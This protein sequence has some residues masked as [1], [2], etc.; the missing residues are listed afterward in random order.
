MPRIVR[1]LFVVVAI[2][3]VIGAYKIHDQG[4]QI[5]DLKHDV[6]RLQEDVAAIESGLSRR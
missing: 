3:L 6:A 4:T 5:R 1:D 2:L